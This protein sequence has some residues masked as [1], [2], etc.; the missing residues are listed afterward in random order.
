MFAG[1]N[2]EEEKMVQVNKLNITLHFLATEKLSFS[3]RI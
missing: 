1:G 2:K 3:F